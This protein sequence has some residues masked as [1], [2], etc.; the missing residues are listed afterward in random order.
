MYRSRWASTTESVGDTV[1][2]LHVLDHSLPLHSGYVFRTQ[3]IL[4]EQRILGIETH[5]LTS[6]KHPDTPAESECVDGFVFHR[7][8]LAA[9]PM[10]RVPGVDQL[11]VVWSLHDR[12][13]R[14][15]GVIKPDVI[16]AHSP[17]LNGLAA[18]YV[19]RRHSIPL[20]YELRASWEDAAVSHGSTRE[21]SVRYRL[22]K[23]LETFVLKRADAIV[24]ICDGLRRDVVSRG[25]D[26]K[27]VSVVANAVDRDLLQA[28]PKF[29]LVPQAL[30]SLAG[31]K[32]IGFFGSFY[33]Y[34]GLDLLVSAI[35]ALK[36]THGDVALMLLGSGPEDAA[37]RRQVEQLGVER[38][39]T[40]LGRVP[41][42]Q[43]AAF[44]RHIDVFVFPRRR[45]RLTE[46]V[47]PL[48]PLEAMAAG[49]LVIASNVG[50]H[51][52]LINDGATGILFPADDV[53]ALVGVLKR[54]LDQPDQYRALRDNGRRYV[55][56]QR[57]W[58]QVAKGY[59][60]VYESLVGCG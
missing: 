22:S 27:R 17:C 12:L 31:R 50:G 60:P 46:I 13:E 52:E 6:A 24:T 49:A 54:V 4:T 41:H 18:L 21:G 1:K 15:V 36:R 9:S 28:A 42:D 32:V 59:L 25:V 14:L 51:R 47:T 39:V 35:A 56:T 43:V 38:D 45:M 44:Y 40:F 29:E 11:R 16:H 53:D 30:Q 37:L 20:V 23:G 57:T 3:G 10:D 26:Q 5:H 33:S 7:T 2:V 34:E 48:K 58:P 8:R 55:H 19:A